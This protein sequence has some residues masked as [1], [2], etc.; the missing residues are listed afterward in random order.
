MLPPSKAFIYWNKLNHHDNRSDGELAYCSING[1]ARNFEYMWDGNR[2]GFKSKIN[3]VGRPTIRIHPTQ[4]PIKLYEWI[5]K[6]YGFNKDGTKRTILDTHFGSLSI[7]IA[8]ADM[9][10][11]LT[12]YEIDE[13]Y[14]K[15]AIKR[16]YNHV[17]Q[18][19][20]FIDRPVIEVNGIDLNEYIKQL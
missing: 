10:F 15:A 9:G 20:A 6:N 16:L 8:C 12:A 18:L 14:F 1:L 11:D 19:N 2:Y 4:K 3:G 17:N 5:L 13:D 7:G